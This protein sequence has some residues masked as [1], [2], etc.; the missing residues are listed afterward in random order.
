MAESSRRPIDK[1]QRVDRH[2][3]RGLGAVEAVPTKNHM[4]FVAAAELSLM[5]RPP[6]TI[7]LRFSARAPAPA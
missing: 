4:A 6:T 3:A 1:R 2:V 5:V 7:N